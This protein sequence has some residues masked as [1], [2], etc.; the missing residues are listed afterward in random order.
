MTTYETISKQELKAAEKVIE[1]QN[2]KLAMYGLTGCLL[3]STMGY[4]KDLY[5]FEGEHLDEMGY[6]AEDIR[7]SHMHILESRLSGFMKVAN[8]RKMLGGFSPSEIGH[9][10]WLAW[11]E[12]GTGF[13]DCSSEY[14]QELDA[15]A[16]EWTKDF[17]TEPYIADDD[18]VWIF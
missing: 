16:V 5:A 3:W 1:K 18:T 4:N 17:P 8:A 15:L 13:F 6:Q 10:F 12:H 14:A 2:V 7:E 9:N 11:G